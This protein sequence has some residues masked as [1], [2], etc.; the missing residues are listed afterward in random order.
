MY[1]KKNL[2]PVE[3]GRRL[4]CSF[5]TVRNRL[6]EFGI[7]FKNPALAR[8][9]YQKFDCTHDPFIRSYMLG[10]RLGDLNV[11][12]RGEHSE[13]IVVR[14]HTTH[15]AQVLVIQSLF[16]PFGR[17]SVTPREEHFTVNCFLNRSFEFLLPKNERVWQWIKDGDSVAQSF[18]AGYV[19]AEANFIINQ[20]R[21]RFKIDS[22]DYAILEWICSWLYKKSISYSYRCI[23]KKGPSWRNQ[24]P[25]NGDLWRL[26]INEAGSL[27]RFIKEIFPF[28]RHAHRIRDVKKCITNIK[29]RRKNGSIK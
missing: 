11:Y 16:N 7:P 13:T 14:C 21:A 23:R 15:K 25:L 6:K 5:K 24:P 27:E 19:D 3:I 2:T 20:G 4:K 28:L 29:L 8:M 1:V 12:K 9:R 22:Y 18:I 17:V 26:N 10:F